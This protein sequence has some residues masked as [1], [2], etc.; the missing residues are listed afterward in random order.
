MANDFVVTVQEL[1]RLFA[2]ELTIHNVIAIGLFSNLRAAT[3]GWYIYMYIVQHVKLYTAWRKH[4]PPFSRF[5]S[6]NDM[7]SSVVGVFLS[8]V[9]AISNPA[10]GILIPTEYS[11]EADGFHFYPVLNI[12][13]HVISSAWHPS[14]LLLISNAFHL[15]C[16]FFTIHRSSFII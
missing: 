5:T 14:C 1:R 9:G 3:D 7:L 2:N 12:I 13:L 11:F 8:P 6:V 15:F 16:H 4:T 10:N